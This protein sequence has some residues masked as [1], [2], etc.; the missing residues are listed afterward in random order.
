[1]TIGQLILK[2]PP[3]GMEFTAFES[4]SSYLQPLLCGNF[5]REAEF[6]NLKKKFYL[7][8]SKFKFTC[9]LYTNQQK[10]GRLSLSIST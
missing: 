10:I 2:V 7:F 3:V 5:I 8:S 1:V 6:N 4:S 9:I